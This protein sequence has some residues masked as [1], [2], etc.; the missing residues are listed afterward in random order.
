LKA[1]KIGKKTFHRATQTSFEQRLQADKNERKKRYS[2]T[3]A[4]FK[5]SA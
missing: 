4:G 5:T 2:Q 3:V 1:L